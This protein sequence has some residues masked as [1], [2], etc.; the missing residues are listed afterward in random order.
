MVFACVCAVCFWFADLK[1]DSAEKQN[2]IDG[3]MQ[4]LMKRGLRIL[5]CDI[6]Y[7]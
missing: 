7:L 6:L 3:H 1:I 4:T 2:A 5:K